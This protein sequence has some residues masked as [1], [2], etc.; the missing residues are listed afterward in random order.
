MRICAKAGELLTQRTPRIL[1]ILAMT[2]TSHLVIAR[3]SRS[4]P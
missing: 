4:N 1:R 3:R 2:K